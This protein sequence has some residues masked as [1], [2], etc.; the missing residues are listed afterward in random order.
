M[1]SVS[2]LTAYGNCLTKKKKG[3]LCGKTD[4]LFSACLLIL[5][6]IKVIF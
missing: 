6:S 2:N 5:G 4:V 3:A 1:N